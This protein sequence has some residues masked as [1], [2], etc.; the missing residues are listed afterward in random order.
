M[1]L[2][3]FAC[4]KTQSWICPPS[5]TSVCSNP[6]CSTAAVILVVLWVVCL[7]GWETSYVSPVLYL[8]LLSVLF[9]RIREQELVP[10]G[11]DLSVWLAALCAALSSSVC[12]PSPSLLKLSFICLTLPL[13]LSCRPILLTLAFLPFFPLPWHGPCPRAHSFHWQFLLVWEG[14][15]ARLIAFFLL[16][17]LR[18]SFTVCLVPTLTGLHT[19]LAECPAIWHSV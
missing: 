11:D 7:I 19:H 13:C 9:L 15:Q 8:I 12:L 14:Y 2:L 1:Y 3:L 4:S 16:Y 18:V 17:S 6:R 5:C 10:L